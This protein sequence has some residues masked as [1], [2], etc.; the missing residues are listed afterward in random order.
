M[1]KYDALFEDDGDIFAGSP[2]SKFWDIINTANDDLVKD[3]MDL[4]IE[5]FTVMETL[6][7]D[8][9]GEEELNRIINEYSFKNSEEIEFN[10]KSTYVEF[11]GE[12]ISR[13]DS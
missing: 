12:I 1:S 2:K 4:L 5:K 8:K 6:L 7:T 3:Q 11:A 13:L 10:K 9:Y